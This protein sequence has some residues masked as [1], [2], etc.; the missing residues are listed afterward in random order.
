LPGMTLTYSDT[1]ILAVTRFG[2]IV[3]SYRRPVRVVAAGANVR[4]L[5][6]LMVARLVVLVL[7]I[8]ANLLSFRHAR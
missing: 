5:D 8:V 4:L 3:A 1:G 2:G 6:H 7:L